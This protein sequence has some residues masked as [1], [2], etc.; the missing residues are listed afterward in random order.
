MSENPYNIKTT[1]YIRRGQQVCAV[2]TGAKQ[3][4]IRPQ[5][6]HKR[7]RGGWDLTKFYTDHER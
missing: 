6:N 4:T 2:S 5:R 1:Y 7:F 3:K